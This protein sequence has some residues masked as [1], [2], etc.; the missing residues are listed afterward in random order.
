MLGNEIEE[1]GVKQ[2]W[3]RRATEAEA[4]REGKTQTLGSK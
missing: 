1:L 2:E 4:R 3:I